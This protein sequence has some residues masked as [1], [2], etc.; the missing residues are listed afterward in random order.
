M[1]QSYKFMLIETLKVA[2][3]TT[4][5]FNRA[6]SAKKQ[7][8]KQKNKQ[9]NKNKQKTKQNKTK[10]KTKQITFTIKQ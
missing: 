4:S 7:K 9:T 10:K 6:M 2:S 5:E 3:L 1:Q 8:Q